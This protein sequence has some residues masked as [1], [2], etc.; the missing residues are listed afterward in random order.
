MAM[1]VFARFRSWMKWIRPVADPACATTTRFSPVPTG[2]VLLLA[3]VSAALPILAGGRT[4][5]AG[6]ALAAVAVFVS[7]L[8]AI[9]YFTGT[10]THRLP[11]LAG[12]GAFYGVFFAI[13]PFTASL[14]WPGDIPIHVYNYSLVSYESAPPLTVFDGEVGAAILFGILTLIGGFLGAVRLARPLPVLSLGAVP[15]DGWVKAVGWFALFV[16][17]A[18]YM[19]PFVQALPS[20]GQLI[21]PLGFVGFGV[22]WALALKGRLSRLELVAVF[23]LALP[24][25]L[26]LGLSSGHLAQ[27]VLLL[28]FFGFMAAAVNRRMMLALVLGTIV[29]TVVGYRPMLLFRE[30]TWGAPGQGMSIAERFAKI[31]DAIDRALRAEEHGFVHQQGRSLSSVQ[32]ASVLKRLNQAVVLGVVLQDTPARIPHWQGHTLAPLPTVMIPRAV[33]KDKPEERAAN[34]FGRRYG[35][36]PP[37]D[38]DMSV[39]LPWL[40]EGYVNFGWAGI[41]AVMGL[42]GAFL[43]ILDRVCNDRGAGIAERAV[44]AALLFPLMNQESNLS[45]TIGNVP[46]LLLALFCL[47]RLASLLAARMRPVAG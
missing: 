22:F 27:V 5:L 17:F 16:H 20:V 8:P 28:V 23:C 12:I 39:N 15:G 31:P 19:L 46:L 10:A 25:R 21:A 14:I 36:I 30:F 2:A 13:G 40:T 34:A 44:G 26:A 35:F 29:L 7:F 11:F 38:H 24:V 37:S 1:V 42:S 32:V 45:L 47:F 4:T 33:W 18:G 43:G 6:G 3:I 41:L 9:L